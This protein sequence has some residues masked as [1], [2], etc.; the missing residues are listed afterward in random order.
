M[1]PSQGRMR[2]VDARRFAMV[3]RNDVPRSAFDIGHIHKTTFAAGALIPVL[4]CEVLPGDSLRLDMTAFTR[5]ATPIVPFMDN[6]AMQSWFFYCPNRIVWENWERM[7]GEQNSPSDVTQFLVPTVTFADA[8]AR[9]EPG[10]IAD[11]FGIINNNTANSMTV[12]SLPFRMYN[13]IW[14]DWFRDEDME[15]KASVLVT[16]GPDP[17]IDYNVLRVRKKHDYFTTARPWPQK[18]VP[19]AVNM[20]GLGAT[21]SDP[22]VPGGNYARRDQFNSGQIGAPV[23]GIGILQTTASSVGPINVWEAGQRSVSYGPFFANTGLRA[24]AGATDAEPDIKLLIND[25]RTAVMIQGLM[26]KN[27]RGGTRY[28]ELVRSH[29]GVV[30]LDARVQRPEY[31]GGGRSMVS[32]NPVAQT[33]ATGLTGGTTPSG[34]LSATGVAVSTRHG[35]S[36]SFT[37]HGFVIGLVAVRADQTYQQGIERFWFRRA[38]FEFYW[39]SLAHLGEQAILSREIYADGSAGDMNVF[40]YQERWSEYKYKPSRTSGM[41]RSTV[42]TPLDIWHLGVEYSVR[43]VLNAGFMEENPP[44]DR[45]LQVSGYFN[46]QFLSDMLFDMRWVR[47]MPMFSIPGVGARL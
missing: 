27:A 15:G 33:S 26:E 17:E 1:A 47:A 44:V 24:R 23:T 45:V 8:G 9:M 42:A 35:F 13:Q 34:N 41:F 6:L 20:F 31:L 38:P 29:F 10:G 18:N 32:I 11:Y 4:C 39:P 30:P 19:N 5:L 7:M 3:P 37:E 2:S 36:A 46:Q 43:P 28:A 22:F 12:I 21:G 14:N 25:L 40:G 16:D